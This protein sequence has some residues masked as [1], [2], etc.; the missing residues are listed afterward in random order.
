LSVGAFGSGE[1]APFRFPTFF[2]KENSFPASF[3]CFPASKVS[4]GS[5]FPFPVFLFTASGLKEGDRWQ[6]P[7]I[8]GDA[9]ILSTAAVPRAG[10]QG[11][12]RFIIDSK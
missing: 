9:G 11:P 7:E 5:S 12:G 2:P 8:H 1:F 3:F 10:H 4:K 6:R